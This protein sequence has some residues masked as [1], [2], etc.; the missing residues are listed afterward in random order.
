[1]TARRVLV[2]DDDRG[3]VRTLCDVLALHGW[4]P[5]AAFDGREA[6]ERWRAEPVDIVVMDVSMPKLD[7]VAALQL[8]RREQPGTLVVLITAL[9]E[10]PVREAARREGALR[11][12]PKPID[13]RQ[14]IGVL[15]GAVQ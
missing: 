14:L 9:A 12:L 15:E 13:L 11:V 8:M 4:S 5:I 6:L 1:M 2:V 10:E 3:M 7:G